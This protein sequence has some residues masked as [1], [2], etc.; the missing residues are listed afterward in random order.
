MDEKVTT[1]FTKKPK[2]PSPHP[3]SRRSWICPWFLLGTSWHLD[4]WHGLPSIGSTNSCS[5]HIIICG[6]KPLNRNLA[7]QLKVKKFL[8]TRWS[9]QSVIKK[10]KTKKKEMRIIP[11]IYIYIYHRCSYAD[12]WP[13][14]GLV[15]H[16]AF[17]A[18]SAR[19]AAAASSEGPPTKI[20]L[21]KIH[22][23]L[24][25]FVPHVRKLD[26]HPGRLTAGTY[27]SPI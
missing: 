24:S 26:L 13:K 6:K 14:L 16:T 11:H 9:F 23:N 22:W 21:V 17:L 27:K 20:K 1:Y 3:T 25:C 4:S 8:K 2:S 5:S 12:S 15:S 7:R 19:Q 10:T 18:F